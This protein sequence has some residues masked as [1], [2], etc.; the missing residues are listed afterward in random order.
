MTES[1]LASVER[2][3]G[4]LEG[5]ALLDATTRENVLVQLGNLKKIS[6]VAERLAEGKLS[7]H[8]WVFELEHGQLDAYDPGIDR[9]IAIS[10]AYKIRKDQA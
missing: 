3:Y 6:C 10:H 8:G 1:T 7:L 4:H 5:Q 2:K 9:F